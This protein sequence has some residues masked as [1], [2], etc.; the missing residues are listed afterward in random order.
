MGEMCISASNKDREEFVGFDFLG[1]VSGDG[2]E[3]LEADLAALVEA[4]L[5]ANPV[6]GFVGAGV[7]GGGV[8]IDTVVSPALARFKSVGCQLYDALS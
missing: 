6:V 8:A 4:T 2:S 1:T 3:P 7:C 5:V